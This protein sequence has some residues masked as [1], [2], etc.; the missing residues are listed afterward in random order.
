MT[1][2]ISTGPAF[3]RS[4]RDFA[5]LGDRHPNG[6]HKADFD[7]TVGIHL[8]AARSICSKRPIS[9]PTQFQVIRSGRGHE[10][11]G[12]FELSVG[13]RDRFDVQRAGALEALELAS[14]THDF[15][16]TIV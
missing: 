11:P 14:G 5:G 3:A 10:V 2:L 6:R 13:R 4:A 12:E 15:P 7:A 1:R 16:E 8:T 9:H